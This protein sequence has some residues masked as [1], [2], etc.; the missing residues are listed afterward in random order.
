MSVKPASGGSGIDVA[1][2]VEGLMQ[3]ERKPLDQIAS[4]LQSSQ[5]RVTDVGR[6]TA[7]LSVFQRALIAL[8]S[9]NEASVES[10]SPQRLTA[11]ASPGSGPGLYEV[12]VL[13]TARP[14]I[15]NIAGFTSV[16]SAQQWFLSWQEESGRSDVSATYVNTAD[17]GVTVSLRS[18][19]TGAA[20]DFV[21]ADPVAQSGESLTALRFSTASNAQIL[22]NGINVS[23]SSNQFD[24]VIPGL[25]ISLEP[26]A[27]SG[28]LISLR[29]SS[30]D[31]AARAEIDTF[32]SAYNELVSTYQSLTRS[33]P[34]LGLKGPLSGDTSIAQAMRVVTQG[35]IAGLNDQTGNPISGGLAALGI[36]FSRLNDGK[37][38]FFPDKSSDDPTGGRWGYDSAIA[39]NL[40]EAGVRFD[41]R[42]GSDLVTRIEE[43]LVSSGTRRSD[44]VYQTYDGVLQERV[45][46]EERIQ[47]DL[48]RRRLD[49]EEK[50]ATIQARYINQ[51]AALDALLFRLSNVSESLKNS[52][53]ALTSQQRI[54]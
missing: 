2:I 47:R 27:Q 22:I 19:A 43:M 50:L 54:R 17:G 6:F 23:S 1:S 21:I 34:A 26:T 37:L 12:E 45:R 25:S 18:G 52:L 30:N 20:A 28:D 3:I 39:T 33:D 32:I 48:S 9:A 14:A 8:R 7:A 13:S 41:F 49:F 5:L 36:R 4:R 29:V 15:W 42:N 53:D 31:K 40:L 44:G 24:N 11:S 46:V 16:A 38:E 10:S 35:L 51:Y